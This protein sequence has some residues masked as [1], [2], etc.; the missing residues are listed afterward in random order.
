M[1]FIINLFGFLRKN[2]LHL[3]VHYTHVIY[4]RLKKKPI[5]ILDKFITV[6]YN[7]N[8]Y[9]LILGFSNYYFFYIIE[10]LLFV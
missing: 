3:T 10:K 7:I 4:P 8:K 6:H 1:F 2:L 9:D 5:L